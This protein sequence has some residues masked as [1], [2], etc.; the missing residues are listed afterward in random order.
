[1]QPRA[2]A[3]QPFLKKLRFLVA[4]S[5]EMRTTSV[6]LVVRLTV[7]AAT[8][9]AWSTD[10]EDTYPTWCADH[11]HRCTVSVETRHLCRAACDLCGDESGL[12]PAPPQPPPPSPPPRRPPPSIATPPPPA[13]WPPGAGPF[14][15][16]F[17]HKYSTTQHALRI[18]NGY[19]AAIMLVPLL[20]ILP[21]LAACQLAMARARRHATLQALRSACKPRSSSPPVW[22]QPRPADMACLPDSCCRTGPQPGASP[23]THPS[24]IVS[25]D[26]SATKAFG[27][28]TVIAEAERASLRSAVGSE[29]DG[30]VPV[31]A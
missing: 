20:A 3:S 27:E 16:V 12:V 19:P 11:Q 9:T 28:Q 22:E 21:L 6:I 24:G 2:A 23:T 10:C 8:S 14:M 30:G 26:E 25:E 4:I 5:A 7:V 15:D 31:K 17:E 1:M 13:S 18:L 29:D